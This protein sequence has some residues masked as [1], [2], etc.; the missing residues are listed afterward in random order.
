MRGKTAQTPR[1]PTHIAPLTRVAAFPHP[2]HQYSVNTL[3]TASAVDCFVLLTSMRLQ[4][5][6]HDAALAASLQL[7]LKPAFGPA[8]Q[9]NK[10]H[11]ALLM[12]RDHTLDSREA[13]R[14]VEPKVPQGSHMRVALLR[15]PIAALLTPEQLT[16]A[17]Y[18][19]IRHL[20]RHC[21]LKAPM[22]QAIV[23]CNHTTLELKR[24]SWACLHLL[25]SRANLL[26]R[27]SSS[28]HFS[29]SMSIMC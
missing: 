25:L 27:T 5:L 23:V 7:R 2:S 11:A 3:W 19:Q 16:Q 4:L 10:I 20:L 9:L 17:N 24:M 28:R 26:S 8:P 14:R 1:L 15:D 22:P 6:M 21:L 12:L 18:K 13:C 29:M